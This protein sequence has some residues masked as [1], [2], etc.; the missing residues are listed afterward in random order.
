MMNSQPDRSYNDFAEQQDVDSL[1]QRD[2]TIV[3]HAFSQMAEYDGLIIDSAQGCWLTDVEG[4]RILDGASSMWC[5]VHGHRHPRIDHAIRQQL[6]RVAHVTNLGM[7][8]PVTIDLATRLIEIAPKGLSHVFFA[9]D[10]A[11]AVEAAMKIA[12]QYWRQ[13]HPAQNHRTKFLALGSAY[14]G[15]TLGAVS[16]GGV[17][18]FHSLF[19]PLL[20][21]V[22]RGPCPD[23]YRYPSDVGTQDLSAYYLAQYRGL[24]EKHASELAACIVEPMVQG[25]AGMVIHPRGFLSGIAQL[26]QEFDCLLI[27]DEV[28]TG[29]GRTGAMFACDHEGVTPDLLC[30]GKGL[31]GGY[32]PMSATLTSHR[33]WQA[34]LGRYE[35]GRSFLHGHTF[36][37][38]PLGAAAAIAVLDLFERERTLEHL[39][40]KAKHLHDR[41]KRLSRFASV[42]DVRQ[43]GLLAAI[44]FVA[45]KESKIPHPWQQQYAGKVCRRI[46]EKNVWLRP[47]GNVLPIVPPLSI[48]S[49]EIDHLMDAVEYGL[50]I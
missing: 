30:L 28:A 43:I 24:F 2:R 6:D 46:L 31:T 42:G 21:S 20:F 36:G 37:G 5:N 25:A 38:N 39:M 4:R 7:S 26:C 49:T 17:S 33:V 12:F 47:L 14:H 32:L 45:D 9:G 40:E 44:D 48:N 22:V 19:E 16:V 41:L 3:W 50:S 35:D 11:S 27:A 29:L 15:D 34:F 10:G 8:H 13:C 1:R 23:A 18:R